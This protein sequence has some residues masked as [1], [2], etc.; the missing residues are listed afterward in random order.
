MVTAVVPGRRVTT[1]S[2]L[3][4]AIPS[5]SAGT[6]GAVCSMRAVDRHSHGVHLLGLGART[7]GAAVA[8]GVV[9]GLYVVRLG[10]QHTALVLRV[11]TVE[12]ELDK[13]ACVTPRG[14]RQGRQT[15]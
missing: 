11:A 13:L 14:S 15:K 3:C 10:A 4:L 2:S 12:E 6:D 8:V 5:V 9:A 1:M 7:L